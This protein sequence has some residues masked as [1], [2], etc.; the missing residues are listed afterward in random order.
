MSI[1]TKI[2]LCNP[3]L[4]AA[5]TASEKPQQRLSSRQKNI[6][7]EFRSWI[8]VWQS[9]PRLPEGNA[10]IQIGSYSPAPRYVRWQGEGVTS[11]KRRWFSHVP[12]GHRLHRSAGSPRRDEKNILMGITLGNL[13][14][15]RGE[16]GFCVIIFTTWR[17]I[18]EG[19]EW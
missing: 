14:S 13:L 16:L 19:S 10:A 6:K 7:T 18:R 2:V 17:S 1:S 12:K 5:R 15:F 3:H 8:V 9:G 11:D 4:A